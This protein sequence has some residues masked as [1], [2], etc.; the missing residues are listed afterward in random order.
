MFDPYAALGVSRSATP[1]EIQE[2]YIRARGQAL[3]AAGADERETQDRLAELDRAFEIV[4]GA[5]DGT[6]TDPT[7]PHAL[8]VAQPTA[9]ASTAVAAGPQRQ[10]PDCGAPN[11]VQVST[12]G[13]CGRQIMRECPA[14]GNPVGVADRVCPRCHT[15]VAE[16]DQRR[17]GEALSLERNIQRERTE[18]DAR[19]RA[20]EEVHLARAWQGVLFW[21]IVL[22]MCLAALGVVVL[23]L[24][25]VGR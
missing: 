18:S 13:S 4:S 12:C 25:R 14:C 15:P 7:M 3:A 9:V 2:A 16:Y 8:V 1:S 23:L 5:V 19:V 22:V 24:T 17:F 11:P 21:A 6:E 10:C 20:Q